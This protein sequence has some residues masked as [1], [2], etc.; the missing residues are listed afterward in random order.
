MEYFREIA[1]A[2]CAAPV[3]T[4]ADIVIVASVDVVVVVVG[5]IEAERISTQDVGINQNH[6]T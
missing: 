4:H 5:T 1:F 6:V 3:H 2:A